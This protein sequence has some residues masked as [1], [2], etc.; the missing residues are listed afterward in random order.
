MKRHWWIDFLAIVVL[1][2]LF[3]GCSEH[4]MVDQGRVVNYNKE[5]RF[6]TIISDVSSD[7]KNPDYSALP[8]V[9]YALPTDPSEMG[10]EPAAGL[11]MK[12]DTGKNAVIIFDPAT[13]SL[14]TIPYTIVEQKEN[15]DKEN[16]L[17]FDKALKQPKPFPVI[18]RENKT[19]T[20]YSKRQ[21]IL[22][23]FSLPDEY[24][25]LPDSTWAAGDEVRIYYKEKGKALRFMNVS[26][27]DIYKK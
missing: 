10:P 27:T 1:V 14:K 3:E 26:K 21:K 19:I 13:Q 2:F 16:P 15:V 4:G 11:R 23:A 24:L 20:I 6:V 18:N 22:V 17:V 5:K 7:P 8:P 25:A 12:L 9:T